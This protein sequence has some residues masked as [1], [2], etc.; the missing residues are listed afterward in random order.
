MSNSEPQHHDRFVSHLTRNAIA[1][2]LA[3]GRGSRL[4]N[5]TDWRAKPAV[6]FGGKFRIIESDLYWVK[7]PT[8]RMPELIQLD[9]GKSIIRNLPPNGTAG[10]ARQSVIFFN[11]DP[12]PPAKINAMALRVK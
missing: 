2:I 6:P 11:R 3:G 8:L 7:T 5:M 1:L 9:K 4:K 10:L 12:R